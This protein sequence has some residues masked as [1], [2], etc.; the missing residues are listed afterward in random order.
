MKQRDRLCEQ[1]T[2]KAE[3]VSA[4]VA[5]VNSQDQALDYLLTL[6]DAKEAC[7]I[8]VSGCELPLSEGA[9]A[10]CETKREKIIAAPGLEP[11]LKDTLAK[12]CAEQHFFFLDRE[13]REHGAGVDIGFTF[14]QA[15]IAETGTLV[16]DSSNEDLR[17][18]TM[19]SEYHVCVLPKSQVVADSYDIEGQL[20]RQMQQ[21]GNYTAFITGASRTADIERV[22]ALGVHGPLE[23][24]I[25]LLED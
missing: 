13:M 8:Q 5:T 15:G 11:A 17:L 16:I 3:A 12:R 2:R 7:R 19:L 1:F 24:H 20:S 9:G 10:L 25:L 21:P 23:L 4:V 18:A 6:C 14:A 22:L